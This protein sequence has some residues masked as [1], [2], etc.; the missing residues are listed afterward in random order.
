LASGL[1]IL[2]LAVPSSS[3]RHPGMQIF[4]VGATRK[5]FKLENFLVGFHCLDL[6]EKKVIQ[7]I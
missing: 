1:T 3:H 4:S 7:G 6:Q 2:Q 5:S